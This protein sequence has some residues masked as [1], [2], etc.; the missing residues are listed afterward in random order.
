VASLTV[1]LIANE[2]LAQRISARSLADRKSIDEPNI[3]RP[4]ASYLFT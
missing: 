3:D 4:N 1:T 2:H